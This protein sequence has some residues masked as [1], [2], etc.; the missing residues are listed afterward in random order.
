MVAPDEGATNAEYAGARL[1]FAAGP[2]DVAASYG[3]QD[4]VGG[5]Y[6]STRVAGAYALGRS[7]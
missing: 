3:Q 7:S 1:G 4:V 6:K 2:V 5:K